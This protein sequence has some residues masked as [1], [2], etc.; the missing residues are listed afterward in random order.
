ALRENGDARHRGRRAPGPGSTRPVGVLGDEDPEE[1]VGL[2]AG[3]GGGVD[4]VDAETGVGGEGGDGPALAR[5]GIEA[6]PVVAALHLR[7]VEPAVGERDPAAG[8]A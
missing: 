7:A 5:R 3:K 2:P 8:T 1:A 6:P 4:P